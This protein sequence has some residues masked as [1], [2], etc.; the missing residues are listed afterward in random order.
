MT[1]TLD[2]PIPVMF[3]YFQI[4]SSGSSNEVNMSRRKSVAKFGWEAWTQS[5][6][7]SEI[8]QKMVKTNPNAVNTSTC[9]KPKAQ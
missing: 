8:S 2:L 5:L 6:G 3:R 1:M 4:D 7:K 9:G